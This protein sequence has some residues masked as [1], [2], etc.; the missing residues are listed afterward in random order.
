MPEMHLIQPR[1]TCSACRP[2][3]RNKG[4][5][6]KL[7]QNRRLTIY[8]SKQSQNVLNHQLAKELKVHSSFEKAIFGVTIFQICN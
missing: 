2:F 1:F 4:T 6:Q 8:L 5:L 7:K 3:T